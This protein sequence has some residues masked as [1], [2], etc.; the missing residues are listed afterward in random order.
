MP[1]CL[2]VD[3]ASVIRRVA[4]KMLEDLSFEVGEAADG[5]QALES[6]SARCPDVLLLDWNMPVMDGLA[7]LRKLRASALPWQPKVIFCTTENSVASIHEALEA[8]ADEY[9]MKP[10]DSDILRSKLEQI[11]LA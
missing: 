3:D 5:R 10:F 6:V 9:I 8:G 2:V 11:G 1:F 4:S 7:C